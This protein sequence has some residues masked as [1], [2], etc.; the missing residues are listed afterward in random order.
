MKNKNLTSF[1]TGRQTAG[2][3]ENGVRSEEKMNKI[4]ILLV[5]ASL[6][7]AISTV[8]SYWHRSPNYFALGM[9]SLLI[10]I[11]ILCAKH[12]YKKAKRKKIEWALFGFLG[13]FNAILI[14]WFVNDV[15]SSWSKGKRYFS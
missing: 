11:N 12:L 5:I 9:F 8:I 15:K 1:C 10:V 14:Y 13:N 4:L 3:S 2:A 7:G 6:A